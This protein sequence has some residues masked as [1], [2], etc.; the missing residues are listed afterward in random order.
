[1]KGETTTEPRIISPGPEHT[2]EFETANPDIKW[3]EDRVRRIAKRA[4]MIVRKSRARSENLDNQ[5][6][7]MVVSAETNMIEWVGRS[8]M[9]LEDAESI[10]ANHA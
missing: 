5:R 6:G 4:G 3:R 1:M 2:D 9:T 7:Y 10:V 8:E